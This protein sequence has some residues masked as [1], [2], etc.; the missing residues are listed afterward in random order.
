MT[1][2]RKVSAAFSALFLTIAASTASAATVG[3]ATAN[4]DHYQ[5]LKGMSSDTVVNGKD[6][7]GMVLT[8]TYAGGVTETLIWEAYDR[9]TNGGAVARGMSISAG[10]QGFM[11]D[12]TS[13]LE[14][15][16]FDAGAADAIFDMHTMRSG[17]GN[18]TGT[19]RGTPFKILG[20]T[21]LDG[22]ITAKYFDIFSIT[23]DPVGIDAYT[24]MTVDFTGLSGGGLLGAL[25]FSTDLDKLAD[26]GDL[27]AVASMPVPEGMPLALSG[28]ALLAGLKLRRR[29]RR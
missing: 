4:G 26:P 11:L 12:A 15:L 28:M 2:F 1:M 8:A 3:I 21:L 7:A 20:D 14:T 5:S 10:W 27:T 13:R 19:K 24:K 25:R 17:D 16:S 9:Y 6:M 18:T 22:H 23:G 29:A